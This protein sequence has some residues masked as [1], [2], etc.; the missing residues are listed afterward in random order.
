MKGKIGLY[1]EVIMFYVCLT[2]CDGVGVNSVFHKMDCDRSV[3]ED[4]LGSS[5]GIRE[6][7]IMTYLGLVEQRT[8]QLLTMQ[9]FLNSRVTNMHTQNHSYWPI[10]V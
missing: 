3:V 4:L 5:S 6:N 8:N 10:S 1:T 2:V 7:N 9:A